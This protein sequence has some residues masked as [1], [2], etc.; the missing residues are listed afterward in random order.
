MGRAVSHDF[1]QKING[2]EETRD[3]IGIHLDCRDLPETTQ[4]FDQKVM[5]PERRK[6]PSITREAKA[7]VFLR[8]G[9]LTR[10]DDW[11]FS[12]LRWAISASGQ[13]S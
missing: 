10:E 1:G 7:N 3:S 13:L 6:L 4:F 11:D 5:R 8:S 2:L 12:D 9:Q